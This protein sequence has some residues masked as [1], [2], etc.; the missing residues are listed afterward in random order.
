MIS[1]FLQ[2]ILDVFLRVFPFV[3]RQADD[4]ARW[5]RTIEGAMP[6]IGAIKNQSVLQ[7][8]GIASI[9]GYLENDLTL[10]E[11]PN[12]SFI[13]VPSGAYQYKYIK[14]YSDLCVYNDQ[15]TALVAH[16]LLK[17]DMSGN[18][19][20]D[21]PLYTNTQDR[22]TISWTGAFPAK[23]NSQYEYLA[24]SEPPR[25]RLHALPDGKILSFEG[26]QPSN[27]SYGENAA[28]LFTR[29]RV[30]VYA[31]NF[32]SIVTNFTIETPIDP[33]DVF[34]LNGKL[35][36][37]EDNGIK[38]YSMTGAYSGVMPFSVQSAY[39][40]RRMIQLWT[41]DAGRI[42]SGEWKKHYYD[43]ATNPSKRINL[44]ENPWI[45][46]EYGED[47]YSNS[48]EYLDN[49]GWWFWVFTYA[50]DRY[51]QNTSQNPWGPSNS[52][53]IYH[54][55]TRTVGVQQ[56]YQ[57]FPSATYCA[58]GDGSEEMAA[59]DYS[60]PGIRIL[61]SLTGEIKHT[62]TIDKL[63]HLGWQSQPQRILPST[64]RSSRYANEG[65]QL[66]SDPLNPEYLYLLFRSSMSLARCKI[67]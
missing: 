54:S 26:M 66:S 46:C 10:T 36:F 27:I 51:T 38:L 3:Q 42:T 23:Y 60:I 21:T 50:V 22:Y 32:A 56:R 14:G 45:V 18:I 7:I 28:S 8:D 15:I 59:F 49:N 58:I 29:A 9:P 2:L 5:K 67:G 4:H 17:M 64:W 47:N 44:A 40:Q 48:Q 19:T 1:Y 52:N 24:H 37:I 35:A 43:P 6:Y 63:E 57:L 55:I 41:S 62:F 25:R 13:Q 16:R 34:V 65:V 53:L 61:S 39:G 12:L 33:F 30:I 20:S 11:F 31:A